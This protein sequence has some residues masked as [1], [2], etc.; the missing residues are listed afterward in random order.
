MWTQQGFAH[1]KSSLTYLTGYFEKVTKAISHDKVV[2]VIYTDFSKT[3]DKVPHD[4][5]IREMGH[6]GSKVL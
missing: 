6:P 1:G 3:F 2:I 5:L 4:G